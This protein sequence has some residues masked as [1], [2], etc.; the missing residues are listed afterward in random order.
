MAARPVKSVFIGEYTTASGEC[1]LAVYGLGSCVAVILFD[2]LKSLGGL[3]HVLLP[4]K[5]PA[6]DRG[7]ELPAKYGADAVDIL[8]EGLKALGAAPGSVKA[9]LVGGAHLF[10]AEMDVDRGVGH[11]NVE[12]LRA[13]LREKGIPLVA[14]ESGGEQGRTV[15]FDL[16]EC[17]LKVRTLRAGWTE[18]PLGKG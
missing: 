14:D 17:R 8:L 5:R 4:G 6:G 18:V 15:F 10:Q 7:E 12:A 11:R 16:P 13:S 1:T 9:A 2:P 3:A